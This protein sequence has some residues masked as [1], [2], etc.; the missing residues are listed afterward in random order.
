MARLALAEKKLK[1]RE[2]VVNPWEPEPEF[3]ALTAEGTPPVLIDLTQ[4][5]TLKSAARVLLL[6]MPMM[7]QNEIH[8]CLRTPLSEPK[9]GGCARG[10]TNVSPLKLTPI[11]SLKKSNAPS[12]RK[13][14]MM[15]ALLT[16]RSYVKG[17]RI[18]QS[19]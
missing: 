19:T 5:G 14:N 6:N 15:L 11:S 7:G 2:T 16:P 8:S 10:S 18:W 4:H 12:S 3:I 1:V 13:R 9:R 17:E